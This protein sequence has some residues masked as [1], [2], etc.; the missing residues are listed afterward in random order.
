MD[1]C[2]KHIVDFYLIIDRN[3]TE[4]GILSRLQR[5]HKENSP[6]KGYSEIKGKPTNETCHKESRHQRTLC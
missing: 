1:V 3:S 2:V 6:S 5:H 4:Y